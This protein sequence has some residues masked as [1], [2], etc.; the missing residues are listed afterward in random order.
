[1]ICSRFAYRNA[2]QIIA[3]FIVT[4]VLVGPSGLKAQTLPAPSRTM[5]KCKIQGTL[6]Y[7]DTPCLGATKLDIE[8]TRGV[9]KLSG[10]ELIGAD[11][12][13]EHQREEF[14]QALRPLSGMD[15]KQ[16]AVA[17]RRYQ[18]PAAAQQECRELDQN[19][20]PVESAEQHAPPAA[21]RDVQM[22]LFQMRTRFRDLR[23]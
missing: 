3:I 17:S 5:Y 13:H 18:L 12:A 21:L 8:P 4:S 23:C 22:R 2:Y 7:S 6:T 15:A 1:M 14:A 20:P 9:S 10:K 11:V 16:L 19:L